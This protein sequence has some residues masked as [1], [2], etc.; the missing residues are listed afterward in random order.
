[1]RS[2][3]WGLPDLVP[4]DAP[5]AWGARA[6]LRN[7]VLDIP[8]DRVDSFFATKGDKTE[9]IDWLKGWGMLWLHDKARTL[10]GDKA[11]LHSLDDGLFHV[12]CNTNASH[13]YLYITVWVDNDTA[14]EAKK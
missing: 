6:I 8:G 10:R 5:A 12:R 13:G 11:E 3:A 1:M 2:L 7:G 9:F 14:Q 4:D